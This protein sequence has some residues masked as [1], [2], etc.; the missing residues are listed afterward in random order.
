MS[1][2]SA[3]ISA[4]ICSIVSIFLS[5]RLI[6]QHLYHFT[7]PK[8]QSKIVG[9][10]WMVPIYAFDS[11]VSLRFTG[12]SLYLDMMRDCYEGYVLYL[13]LALCIAYIGKGNDYEV[14]KYC[15]LPLDMHHPLPIRWFI[16]EPVPRGEDFLRF[17]K[18]G[19]LQYSLLKP[20]MTMLAMVLK[21]SDCYEEGVWNFSSGWAYIAIV[22][23]ISVIWAFYCL[24][25]FYVGLRK[26][27]SPY[28]PIPKFL[29]VKA[30]LFLCFWQGFF[31]SVMAKFGL[32]HSLGEFTTQNV[33]LAVQ[34]LLICVEMLAI[35]I[36]HMWAFP[37]EP[38]VGGPSQRGGFFED[39]FAQQSTIKDF[40][41]VLPILIPARFQT[42]A[43]EHDEKNPKE[44]YSI[45]HHIEEECG[46]L[47]TKLLGNQT[48]ET[49]ET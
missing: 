14:L 45:R 30:I 27:L 18:F 35:S 2:S 31:I 12:V 29:C 37:Y 44:E 34:D 32:I 49:F 9:I 8:V 23:N 47:V 24:G 39:N 43:H 3:W 41:E 46:A 38:F 6:F 40:Q 7:N 13:F 21:L 19:T 25:M 15:D 16:P 48:Y 11:W 4:G 33:A 22:D 20:L 5:T 36:V 17:C 10:L 26:A 28:D 42:G 1:H